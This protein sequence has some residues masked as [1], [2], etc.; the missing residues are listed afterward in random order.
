MEQ[1]RVLGINMGLP[2]AG[3]MLELI[4]GI[5]KPENLTR[6]QRQE[7]LSAWDT[8]HF[9]PEEKLEFVDRVRPEEGL[10]GEEYEKDYVEKIYKYLQTI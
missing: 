10:E 4:Q 2:G 5:K 7:V 3:I 1:L 8:R 6:Q 9:V